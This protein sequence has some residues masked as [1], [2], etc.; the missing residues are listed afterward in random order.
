MSLLH[1]GCIKRPHRRTTFDEY[2]HGPVIL[3][4][5]SEKAQDGKGVKAKK[6]K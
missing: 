5:K 4:K 1:V 2:E 3:P 6:R